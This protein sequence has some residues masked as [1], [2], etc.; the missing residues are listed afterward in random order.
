MERGKRADGEGRGA[1]SCRIRGVNS[2]LLQWRSLSHG[3]SERL[4]VG[5]EGWIGCR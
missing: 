1:G 4:L 3:S 5:V 2:T